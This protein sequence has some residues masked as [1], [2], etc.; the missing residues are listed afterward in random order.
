MPVNN[1]IITSTS[2]PLVQQARSLRQRKGRDEAG[3]FLVEGIHPV[4]EAVESGWEI[5][6]VFYTED[7]L[8]SRFG[9]DLIS[10]ASNKLQSVSSRV[11]ESLSEKDN[12]QGI[13]AVVHKKTASLSDIAVLNCGVAVVS[14]QDPGNVGTILR[15]LDAVAADGLFLLDGGVDPYHP[16]SVRASMGALFWKP[17]VQT[18]FRELMDWSHQHGVQLIA[19]S[20]HAEMDY[21]AFKPG[22]RWILILGSEQKGL[23]HGQIEACDAAISVPMRGRSSSLNLA[24]AAA[25]LLYQFLA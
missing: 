8:A 2:N 5:D 13:I 19:T 7:I 15:T 14:P 20:A 6:S 23:D 18:S 25:V 24:V 9:S 21:R 1:T 3:L 11:L 10:K 17:I 22:P 4:G 12:P 16:T